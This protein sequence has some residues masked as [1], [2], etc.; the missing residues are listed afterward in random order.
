MKGKLRWSISPEDFRVPADVLYLNGRDI[1]F[2]NNVTSRCHRGQ[3]DE[4]ETPYRKDCSQG[5]AYVRKDLFSIKNGRLNINIELTLCKCLIR[6]VM[7][8]ACPTWEYAA[9]ANLLKL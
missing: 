8:H 6:S 7:T 5:L 9:D 1:P 2:V 4:M 3:E